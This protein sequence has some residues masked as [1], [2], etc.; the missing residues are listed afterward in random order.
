MR[1]LSLNSADDTDWKFSPSTKK[2][3][4]RAQVP[5]CVHRDLLRSGLIPDPFLGE[6][7]KKVQWIG[8]TDWRYQTRFVFTSSILSEARIELVCESIDTIATISLNGEKIGM[9]DNMFRLF[10]F[11]ISNAAKPGGNVLEFVFHSAE[12]AVQNIRPEHTPRETMDPVGGCTKLRKQ[13]SQ[14]GWDW[15][16]R[17]LT[18]G[19]HGDLRIEAYSHPRIARVAIQ[20]EHTA[21]TVTLSLCPELSI[22]VP[23]A[24]NLLWRVTL[25]YAGNI[26]EESDSLKIE[27]TSP[28]LWWPNGMGDQEL[29]ELA[30][31][32]RNEEQV[33]D[34]WTQR[35][36]LRTLEL[37]RTADAWGESFRF[38][39]NGRPLFAKGANWVPAHSFV[40][41]LEREDYLSLLQSTAEANMN[42]IRVWGGG[43]YESESFYDLCDE[44][45]ILVWQDFMFACT[46]YPGDEAFIES[47]REEAIHQVSRLRNR[48]CLA[49]WCGNNELETHNRETLKSSPAKESYDKIFKQ[50]LPQIV[51]GHDGHTAYWRS[52]PSQSETEET[53]DRYRSGDAHFWQVWFARKSP[54]AYEEYVFRFVSEFGMQS[55]ASKQTTLSYCHEDQ[56]NVFSPTCLAHQKNPDGNAIILDYVYRRY[57]YA[58]DYDSLAYLS[59]LN[60]AYCIKVG[61]EHY[62]R[63]Q[64][65]CG[66]ALYWQLNDCWPGASWSSI[67]FGGRWKALHY[68][69]KRFFAP[70]LISV[71]RVTE[72]STDLEFYSIFD[73]PEDLQAKI[74]WQ[75][76]TSSGEQIATD[77]RAVCLVSGRSQSQ[78]TL[79]LSEEA[80]SRGAENLILHCTLASDTTVLSEE[81][82]LF[83]Q[84][85][86][87][88]L[89][90]APISMRLWRTTAKEYEI[91]LESE[92]YHHQVEIT[93][94]DNAQVIYSDNYFDL[95]PR[96]PKRITFMDTSDTDASK[97]R[98]RSLVNSY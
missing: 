43:I 93:H 60:Q 89:R 65:R 62:R 73:G 56:L 11:D 53:Q 66:G 5:G 64:E 52:S 79:D 80:A 49:L 17:L 75:L 28:R 86:A 96:R 85:Q 50:L 38:V 14:F 42:M 37:R 7:E 51:H 95:L 24:G 12:K 19:I 41:G 74:S 13:Q 31:E 22:D 59:Q 77:Q 63:E 83:C 47:V 57:R 98:V 68:A 4:H 71:K 76:I 55:F 44:L 81:F 1:V 21:Q 9:V 40:A 35:I 33:L 94:L 58:K 32:L 78:L 91:E 45:G 39:V 34:S 48:T 27:I 54:K 16:P 20:Q 72:F 92:V 30:I 6:N 69:A 61:V 46:L 23:H 2:T 29:Y 82:V 97:L 18:C 70:A 88:P 10:R 84:P 67:E 26:V 90:K 8:H 36:G 87:L 15:A 25:V 3:W